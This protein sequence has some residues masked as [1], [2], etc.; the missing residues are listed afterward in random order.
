MRRAGGH[1]RPW[2]GF[3]PGLL[4]KAG[5]LS[6]VQEKKTGPASFCAANEAGTFGAD[7]KR[8]KLSEVGWVRMRETIRLAGKLKRVT[9][10]DEADR[11]FASIMV[12]TD[13]VKSVAQPLV[14]VGV[15]L[16]I[17]TLATLSSGEAVP[18]RKARRTR[19]CRSA[20][21]GPAGRCRA[22]PA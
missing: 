3:L 19:R 20:C 2:R 12:E 4:R 21:A 5:T 22:S 11:W 8:I 18:D 13:D 6:Q 14:A 17:T 1:H 10:S 9:I 15:D 7:G 16:G